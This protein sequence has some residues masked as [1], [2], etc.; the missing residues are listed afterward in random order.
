MRK[1]LTVFLAGQSWANRG[2]IV[3]CLQHIIFYQRGFARPCLS[4][5]QTGASV[6]L[7]A[8]DGH[9]SLCRKICCQ[10][11]DDRF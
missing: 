1:D 6:R 5:V 9:G 11:W 8:A 3:D 2:Q 10:V 4:F 7:V